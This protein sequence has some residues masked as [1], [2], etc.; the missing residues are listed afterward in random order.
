MQKKIKINAKYI[1]LCFKMRT[2]SLFSQKKCIVIIYF[3]FLIPFKYTRS[4]CID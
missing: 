1:Y 3:A 2:I 4:S